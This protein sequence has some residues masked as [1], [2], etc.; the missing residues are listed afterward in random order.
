[1][2]ANWNHSPPFR[3]MT[4]HP[5]SI[6]RFSV[7]STKPFALAQ[8]IISHVAQAILVQFGASYRRRE[9]IC[10]VGEGMK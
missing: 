6:Q 9:W 5:N 2:P 3:T 7:N 8:S 10:A 4:R 1:M